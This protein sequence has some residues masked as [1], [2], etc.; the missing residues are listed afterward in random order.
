MNVPYIGLCLFCDDV[1][2]EVG[3]KPS[4]MGVY[5]ADLLF[6][7][8][9]PIVLQKLAVIVW[10]ISDRDNP[11]KRFTIR[12]LMPPNRQEIARMDAEGPTFAE[13]PDEL[14]KC[15]FVRALIQLMNVVF[16]EEGHIEV[17]VDVEGYEP[18]R[19]GRLRI[20]FNRTAEQAGLAVS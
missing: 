15:A 20:G 1:R 13:Q 17:M 19:A 14:S 4:F 7:A 12:I 9:P 10:I 18:F 16:T 5:A 2:L 3:N 6:T 8:A 11:P